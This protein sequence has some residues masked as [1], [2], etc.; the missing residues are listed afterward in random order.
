MG[1]TEERKSA[2]RLFVSAAAT[3]DQQ[4]EACLAGMHARDRW[5]LR[6]L[7]CDF[8]ATRSSSQ[9]L[10]YSGQNPS[11]LLPG[12]AASTSLSDTLPSVPAMGGGCP[13]VGVQAARENT[14]GG[15][16]D[17]NVRASCKSHY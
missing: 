3:D 6:L 11:C 16:E 1:T 7:A 2:Q 17:T 12:S 9:Q 14:S 5:T 13:V 15:M 10:P 8:A 4:A